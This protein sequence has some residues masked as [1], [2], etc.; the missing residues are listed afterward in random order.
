MR[1]GRTT[2]ARIPDSEIF[3]IKE[4]I[5][6]PTKKPKL[7]YAFDIDYP[8]DISGYVNQ[9]VEQIMDEVERISEERVVELLRDKGYYI[10]DQRWRLNK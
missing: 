9:M 8:F 2:T 3:D 1:C 6:G 10:L 7:D 5:I 4:S